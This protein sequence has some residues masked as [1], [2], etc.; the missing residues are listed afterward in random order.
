M[1]LVTGGSGFLGRQVCEQLTNQGHSVL[2]A[3]L[4]PIQTPAY[5]SRLV[6]IS[7]AAE[8]EGLFSNYPVDT[9]IHLA[10]LLHTESWKNPTDAYRVNVQGS[11]HLLELARKYQLRR[12]VFGSTVDALGYHPPEEGAVNE[13]AEVLPSD[14]YGETKR[15]IENLGLAYRQIYGLEFISSR[16]PFIVGPGTTTPTSAWRMDIFNLLKDGGE[17]DLGF[18]AEAVIPIAH[19]LDSAIET[20]TLATACSP[21]HSIYH[22]PCESIRVADLAEAV[23]RICKNLSIKYG[24]K[25]ADFYP[26]RVDFSR[27][28]KEFNLAHTPLFTRLEEYRFRLD[29]P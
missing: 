9:V 13:E 2:D 27:F 20:C 17:I 22:L 18:E 10:A 16:I 21:K 4:N 12:F 19:V 8:L 25:K 15:F 5:A 28:Q 24:S 7:Q 1:I 3:S 6:D 23:Q 11:F 26:T 14:L 29:H